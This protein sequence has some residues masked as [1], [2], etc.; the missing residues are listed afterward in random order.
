M[1]KDDSLTCMAMIDPVTGWFEILK[2]MTFDLDE[3]TAGN[4]EYI[5][6]SSAR[7]NQLFN[8]TWLCRYLHPHKVVFDNVSEFK[9]D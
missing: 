1:Q 8:N 6:K 4:D 2:I 9:R 5:Y 7:V 3:V